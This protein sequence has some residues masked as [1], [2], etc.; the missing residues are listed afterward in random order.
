M[1]KK[2]LVGLDFS[3]A[4][5]EALLMAAGLA[6]RYGAFLTLL[7]VHDAAP[8]T[9]SSDFELF[10]AEQRDRLR[11]QLEKA[12]AAAQLQASAAGVASV[13]TR[14]LEGAPANVIAHYAEEGGF[15]L[16]VLAT[17]GR[18]GLQHAMLGSVAERVVRLAP[19]PVLTVRPTA[20]A[21]GGRG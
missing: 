10:T 9:L 8:Y 6:A 13:Q 12:L 21:E 19:C 18:R 11:E 2:I 4:S 5:S 15:D 20:K 3:P 17:H 16:V 14:L 7:H 1:F